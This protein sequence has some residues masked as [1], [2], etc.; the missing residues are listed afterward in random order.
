[1]YWRHDASQGCILRG[2]PRPALGLQRQL[3]STRR[4]ST[5]SKHGSLQ[6]DVDTYAVNEAGGTASIAVTR[7][8]GTAGAVGATVATGSGG[9]AQPGQDFTAMSHTVTFPDGE[10]GTK[11]VLVTIL[12]DA[13]PETSGERRPDLSAATGGATLGTRT[14]ATLTITDDDPG[15]R[16]GVNVRELVGSG[17]VLQLN[18]GTDLAIPASG[19]YVFTTL[20][21]AGS[22]IVVTV[23]TQ[24]SAPAQICPAPTGAPPMPA[25][26]LLDVAIICGPALPTG[27]AGSL[28]ST[29]R[30][31]GKVT[32]D[33]SGAP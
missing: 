3:E 23:K 19:S 15:Y 8:G 18:G 32:T 22:V 24:P 28:D 29:F 16:L 33:F 14:A 9:S 27:T 26:D 17:L 13:V 4:Q 30:S 20:L 2:C 10:G 1:M 12:N 25:R 31:G 11:T 21:A 6:F 5:R 7:T